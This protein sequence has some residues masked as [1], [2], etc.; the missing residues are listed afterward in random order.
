MIAVANK[1]RRARQSADLYDELV[2]DLFAGGGGASV[3]IEEALGRSVDVAVDH[4]A[5]AVAMH[6]ANHPHTLHLR[7]DVFDVDP[8]EAT[9]GRSVGLLWASPDCTYHS[10]A[11]GAAPI[12]SNRSR[13]RSLAW[14]VIRWATRVQPRVIMLENVEEFA[15][16]C[17]LVSLRHPNG[18][19]VKDADGATMMRPCERRKGQTFRRWVRELRRLGYAVEWRELRACDYGSPTTRKRLFVVARRDGQPIVWP[20][21]TH[22]GLPRD[23]GQRGL[24]ATALGSRLMPFRTAAECLDWSLPCP[25]IFLSGDE[26]KRLGCRRPLKPATLAR[27]ARGVKRYIIDATRPFVVAAGGTDAASVYAFVASYYG[28]GIGQDCRDPLR[29]IPTHE[30]FACVTV[31]GRK[32]IIDDIGMRMLTPRE[33]YRCQGFGEDYVIDLSVDGRPLTKTEQVRLVGNSVCPQVAEALVRANLQAECRGRSP[34]PRRIR[35]ASP[36]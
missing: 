28:T 4:D 23:R 30:R 18:Q 14:V 17:P 20:E 6:R 22:G 26:A 3:G 25:S 7:S 5:A 16:W 36:C 2:V 19:P 34:R 10:K 24:A 35:R 27:I 21:R 32:H 15:A 1:R 8:E 31:V 33:M 11:R 9:G 13:R 29:T 12:R